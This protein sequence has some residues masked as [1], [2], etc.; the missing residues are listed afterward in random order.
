LSW[1]SCQCSFLLSL[2]VSR[3]TYI[4]PSRYTNT[5]MAVFN[6]RIFVHRN[7]PF[8]SGT[9]GIGRSEDY[10]ATFRDAMSRSSSKPQANKPFQETFNGTDTISNIPLEQLVTCDS[11]LKKGETPNPHV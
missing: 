1:E 5:L 9:T 3:E 8:P 4:G 10:F 6:N 2:F 11:T 7:M